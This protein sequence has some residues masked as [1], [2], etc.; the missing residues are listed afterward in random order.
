MFK[1]V[2]EVAAFSFPAGLIYKRTHFR[3]VGT[4]AACE[5]QSAL[6]CA[7]VHPSQK[8]DLAAESIGAVEPFLQRTLEVL[9]VRENNFVTVFGFPVTSPQLSPV[10]RPPDDHA[11]PT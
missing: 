2:T 7:V 5:S 9:E 6:G 3:E 11:T 1:A 8:L 10:F 4:L